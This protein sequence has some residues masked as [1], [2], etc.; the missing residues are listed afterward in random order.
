MN[1]RKIDIIFV[2]EIPCIVLDDKGDGSHK[3]FC[4]LQDKKVEEHYGD[5]LEELKTVF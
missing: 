5:V 4:D 2:D 1:G 3:N